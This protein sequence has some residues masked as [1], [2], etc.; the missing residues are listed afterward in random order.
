MLAMTYARRLESRLP[1]CFST[2]KKTLGSGNDEAG[3]T[4]MDPFKDWEQHQR[5]TQ[6]A[7]HRSTEIFGSL[8]KHE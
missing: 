3:V 1:E 7:A 8:T 2:H 4:G 5:I 6:A